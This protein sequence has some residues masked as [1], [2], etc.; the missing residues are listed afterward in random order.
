MTHQAIRLLGFAEESTSAPFG[1]DFDHGVLTG[2]YVA[3]V[4]DTL[5][6]VHRVRRLRQGGSEPITWCIEPERLSAWF[7][8]LSRREGHTLNGACE[9]ATWMFR[10]LDHILGHYATDNIVFVMDR[11]C[12]NATAEITAAL[13]EQRAV[14][15]DRCVREKAGQDISPRPLHLTDNLAA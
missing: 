3:L 12:H 15:L 8:D 14:E 11:R 13:T 9:V 1:A 6:D 5:L 7:C 2:M 4:V 10:Q